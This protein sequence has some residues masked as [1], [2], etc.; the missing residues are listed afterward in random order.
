LSSGLFGL[1]ARILLL[2]LQMTDK[3][4]LNHNVGVQLCPEFF[5]L[6][7]LFLHSYL[8]ILEELNAFTK[9]S[10]RT[11]RLFEGLGLVRQFLAELQVRRPQLDIGLLQLFQVVVQLLRLLHRLVTQ[12]VNP[13]N[14]NI[15][16]LQI[17]RFLCMFLF[18]TVII[19]V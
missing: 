10:A 6:F 17:L 16:R 14:V 1:F 5:G 11:L 2:I 4:I 8:D 19:F 15:K 3:L 7:N 18:E 9:Q 12:S 13:I